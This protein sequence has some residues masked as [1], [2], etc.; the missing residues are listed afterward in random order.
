[1]IRR[2][3]PTCATPTRGP[4]PLTSPGRPW[5]EAGRRAGP[6][7][8]RWRATDQP[9]RLRP[10]ARSHATRTTRSH[11][12]RTTGTA[13]SARTAG[14]AGRIRKQLAWGGRRRPLS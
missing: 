3:P 9:H 2:R 6:P 13:G 7:G 11:A 5:P 10:A 12:T 1:L 8:N 4:A 14:T